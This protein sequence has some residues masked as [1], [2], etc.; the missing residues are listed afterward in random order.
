MCCE[1]KKTILVLIIFLLCCICFNQ[2]IAEAKHK[3]TLIY[4]CEGNDRMTVKE[5]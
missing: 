2:G 1:S 5:L 3:I 4:M